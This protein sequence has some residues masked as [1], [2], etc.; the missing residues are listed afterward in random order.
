MFFGDFLCRGAPVQTVDPCFDS[1]RSQ[2]ENQEIPVLCRRIFSRIEI[3]RKLSRH[4]ILS[5]VVSEN[6]SSSAEGDCSVPSSSGGSSSDTLDLDSS[7]SELSGGSSN[8][9]DGSAEG[10]QG[11]GQL[12]GMKKEGF[13]KAM[14]VT[15]AAGASGG[16]V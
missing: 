7:A 15:D 10:E 6:I 5:Q 4:E 8:S 2:N 16:I 1:A 3:C 13:E 12:V 9:G 11:L 14:Q